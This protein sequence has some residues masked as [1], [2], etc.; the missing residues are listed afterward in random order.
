MEGT[1]PHV[2]IYDGVYVLS[3]G[4][5][6]LFAVSD[7]GS[8]RSAQARCLHALGSS[9]CGL[10]CWVFLFF[11]WCSCCFL[12][13]LLACCFSHTP[14]GLAV[15]QRCGGLRVAWGVTSMHAVRHVCEANDRTPSGTMYLV[16]AMYRVWTMYR[17]SFCFVWRIMAM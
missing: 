1:P 5:D 10:F 17:V 9:G 15:L 14:Q 4:V 6:S 2:V 16:R 12:F 11:C 3:A 13:L 8:E 7:F